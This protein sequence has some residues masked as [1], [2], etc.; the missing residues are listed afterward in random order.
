MDKRRI[1]VGDKEYT[2]EIASNE[3]DRRQGLQGRDYLQ[4][5]EGMLFVWDKQ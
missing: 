1:I 3:E 4:T 2:V 5:D